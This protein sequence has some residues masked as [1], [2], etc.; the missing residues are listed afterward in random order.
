MTHFSSRHPSSLLVTIHESFWPYFLLNH[1]ILANPYQN[2][3]FPGYQPPKIF[4]KSQNVQ[5]FSTTLPMI[6]NESSFN[7]KAPV[8]RSQLFIQRRTTFVVKKKFA[9]FDHLVVCCCIMLYVV[10][11]CCMLLYDV[12]LSLLSIKNVCGTNIVR[13]KISFVF[14][15]VACCCLRLTTF[16]NFV[17][18]APAQWDSDFPQLST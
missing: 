15:D 8:K 6:H 4:K 2:K 10:V 1:Y 17:V 7:V 18:F 13:Q 12:A 3:P 16:P 14:R 9:P 11:S 5:M